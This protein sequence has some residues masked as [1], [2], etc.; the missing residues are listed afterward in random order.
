MLVK[1]GIAFWSQTPLSYLQQ[2]RS[3]LARAMYFKT[4]TIGRMQHHPP[5]DFLLFNI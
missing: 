2:S 1:S 4:S 5:E 3:R